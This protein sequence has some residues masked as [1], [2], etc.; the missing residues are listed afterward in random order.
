M[1]KMIQIHNV[2]DVLHRKPKTRA[3][4]AGRSLS[5][6]CFRNCAEPPK[7]LGLPEFESIYLSSPL[8][9]EIG[10]AQPVR[11]ARESR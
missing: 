6:I 2:P 5:D 10:T 4:T 7:W 3:A 9:A 11:H 1:W 8:S